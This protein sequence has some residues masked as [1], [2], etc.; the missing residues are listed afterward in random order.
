MFV[1]FIR[2]CKTFIGN[3]HPGKSFARAFVHYLKLSVY[4]RFKRED[5]K[6]AQRSLCIS[7]RSLRF[8]VFNTSR[9]RV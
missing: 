2:C 1:L 8:T 9:L 5:A 6:E 4:C 7:S 3:I